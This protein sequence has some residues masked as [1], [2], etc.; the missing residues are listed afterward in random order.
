[1][2]SRLST[3]TIPFVALT[4]WNQQYEF[5]ILPLPFNNLI[6]EYLIK[7]KASELVKALENEYK[8]DIST[9]LYS[10]RY[11]SINYD[12]AERITDIYIQAGANINFI[13]PV[14]GCTPVRNLIAGDNFKAVNYLL[15]LGADLSI[16]VDKEQKDLCTLTLAEVYSRYPQ[17]NGVKSMGSDSIDF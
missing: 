9:I 12:D 7:K 1:M 15:S 5:G 3:I 4:P 2:I 8:S 16:R 14:N 10:S 6:A 13:N 11:P 17:I